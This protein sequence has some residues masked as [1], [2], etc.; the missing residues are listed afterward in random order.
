[1][2][3]YD[4]N[5]ATWEL[6]FA[7][8]AE[9]PEEYSGQIEN[10]LRLVSGLIHILMDN[11]KLPRKEVLDRWETGLKESALQLLRLSQHL[12]RGGA[13][14][15]DADIVEAFLNDISEGGS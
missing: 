9:H 3:H 11:N 2:S 7:D 15:T 4:L 1:M 13:D 10:I 14:L 12:D 5:S 8:R 6:Y